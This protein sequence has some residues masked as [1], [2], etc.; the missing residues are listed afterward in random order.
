VDRID[1]VRADG[2]MGSDLDVLH[3]QFARYHAQAV[4][5]S[6]LFDPEEALREQ[7][8]E[9]PVNL[10]DSLGRY[11]AAS[12]QAAAV[13]PLLGDVRLGFQL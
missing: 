13:D 11:G 10:T 6:R 1:S 9:T 12:L 2:N 7:F 3:S 5:V 8:V 4:T